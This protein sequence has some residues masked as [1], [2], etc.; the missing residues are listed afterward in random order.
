M[1]AI[2]DFFTIYKDAAWNKDNEAILDLY[3]DKALIFDMWNKGFIASGPE[4]T[5]VITSW[6]SSLG[7]EQ[8]QVDFQNVT[9]RQSSD[10]GYATAL[11]QFK[12]IS[13]DG[14]VLRSMRNRI[15]L[16]FAKSGNAW[17]VQHQHTSAPIHPDRL[18]AILDI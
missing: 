16:G 8:V 3:D 6:L 12:A 11:I 1:K 18:T 9:I 5:E 14:L 15:T 2:N 17:K 4:W 13:K 10:T 7:D